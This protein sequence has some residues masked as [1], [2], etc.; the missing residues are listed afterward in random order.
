MAAFTRNKLIW[1]FFLIIS[2]LVSVIGLLFNQMKDLQ[3]TINEVGTN[4]MPSLGRIIVMQDDFTQERIVLHKM[5]IET[6]KDKIN[7]LIETFNRTKLKFIAAHEDYKH[8]V[9]SDEEQV[10]YDNVVASASRYFEYSQIMIQTIQNGYHQ[11]AVYMLDN[12]SLIR[13]ET[14]DAFTEWINFNL[15]GTQRNV[16]KSADQ[17]RLSRNLGV[18]LTI[19]AVAVGTILVI[20][21]RRIR[22]S[23]ERELLIEK[24]RSQKYL[25]I[26]EVVVIVLN[27]EGTIAL[28]N[29]EGCRLLG[30][31]A[32][33]LIGQDIGLIGMD[34]VDSGESKVRTRYGMERILS[35]KSTV[36]HNAQGEVV[37][38][39]HAGVDITERKQ[40]EDT[41]NLYK[42][43]LEE[44]VEQRT[45]ELGHKNTL[46]EEAK[47]AAEAANR[48]KSE[49][50]AN[51]SHEIR[52][53]LNAISG[54][55]YLLR[56]TSLTEQ[57]K[58]YVD[59]TISSSKGLLAIINDILD[60]SKIEAKKIVMEQVD[61]DLF[62]VINH[63]LN[64][65]SFKAYDKGLNFQVSIHHKVPQMLKGD[66]FRLSQILLNLTNNA[67][68]FT[69]KG[70]VSLSVEMVS[71]QSTEVVML[72]FSVKDT[73]IGI[74]PE[75]QKELFR[76]FTQADMSTARKY[77]GTG[78]GL[79]IS[80]NLVELMGGTMQLE[81][82]LHEGSNFTFTAAFGASEGVALEVS[83][84]TELKSLQVLI[85][86]SDLDMREIL[87][88]Q[89]NQFHFDVHIADSEMSAYEH[90]YLHG[91][92]DLVIVDWTL[93]GTN[94]IQL[95]ESLNKLVAT[96]MQVIVL[97]SA[98]YEPKLQE[99]AQSPDLPK[100]LGY[101][102]S[103]SQLFNEIAAL[104][105]KQMYRKPAL[106]RDN[107]KVNKFSMLR[108]ANILLV[109]D[110]AINQQVASEIL[111]EMGVNIDIAEDGYEAVQSVQS[112]KYD[113]IL[114]DLQ[115]P[116]M[117]GYEAARRI[118][119]LPQ[120][121]DIPIIAMTADAMKGVNEQVLEAG[122][123]S[124]LT[125]PFDPIQ[126]FS[127]LKRDIQ[128]ARFSA[129]SEVSAALE[130]PE[131][132]APTGQLPGLHVQEVLAKLTNNKELYNQIVQK[133]VSHH[134][135]A[136]DEIRAA[137][138]SGNREQAKLLSH[139]LKGAASYIGAYELQRI[140][141]KL[142]LVIQE[143]EDATLPELLAEAEEQ[144]NIVLESI[145]LYKRAR[146]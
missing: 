79:V 105:Q 80:K 133:F 13:I 97:I 58:D 36:V 129:F 131:A 61:F 118:R 17:Q 92:F 85:V 114:M 37:S 117:D 140:F 65:I 143:Q 100:V 2:L 45:V 142:Q 25:D 83:P 51:M 124:Y 107:S 10:M 72:K 101:P 88:M 64:M 28:V 116:R 82:E 125:K 18:V 3:F 84:G 71:N 59:K 109:E 57:Q 115:M 21:N 121:Q 53:P 78:L 20:I 29:Q 35:W 27:R 134:S 4:W 113:A 50:L 87:K 33:E 68:K 90:I 24:K 122:M 8:L 47:E 74:S 144:M 56:Q 136:V 6:D 111:K 146:L 89:M 40:A 49:F 130:L 1:S 12:L 44:L 19:I 128:S 137:W 93:V 11:S 135:G 52:T 16:E 38:T 48:A 112:K 110:N 67:V 98:F 26:I 43:H 31:D 70:G 62:E 119:K 23:G 77:G 34:D 5:L 41:L 42:N 9:I 55:T 69:E 15:N 99:M 96:P 103:Q 145:T 46:L 138:E 91:R 81:S 75:Q 14:D 22:L 120:T 102:M 86:S 127:V 132:P 94:A 104:V 39:I 54:L 60:F 108:G 32:S 106:Q 95:V 139:T 126:L 73:G 7:E 141:G 66:P 76:E 63:N 30:Y 123:N